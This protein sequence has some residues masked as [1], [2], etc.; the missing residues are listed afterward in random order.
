MTKLCIF[1]L[2]IATIISSNFFVHSQE[3]PIFCTHLRHSLDEAMGDRIFTLLPSSIKVFVASSEEFAGKMHQKM[4]KFARELATFV[5]ASEE[6]KDLFPENAFKHI[7][8]AEAISAFV[9]KFTS[10]T[11]GTTAAKE[12]EVILGGLILECR[13]D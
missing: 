6:H 1:Q 5:D 10:S 8:N 2:L 12:L 3:F 4:G 7:I 13:S 11:R 9:N